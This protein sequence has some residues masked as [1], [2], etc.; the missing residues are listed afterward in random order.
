M[1]AKWLKGFKDSINVSTSRSTE[2]LSGIVKAILSRYG[3]SL[4]DKLMMQTY[5]GAAV[6]S[7]H[8]N[9]LQTLIRQDYPYA[10]FSTVQ[11]IDLI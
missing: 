1:T 11:L 7:G 8:L 9:G 4:K 10:F 3:D 6:M 5:D 2:T